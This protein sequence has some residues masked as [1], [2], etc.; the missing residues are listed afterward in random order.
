MQKRSKMRIIISIYRQQHWGSGT[1]G[2]LLQIPSPESMEFSI[3]VFVSC[4]SNAAFFG[5]CHSNPVAVII[6]HKHSD[7]WT[8]S[9]LFAI[10]SK[11]IT[12]S[13]GFRTNFFLEPNNYQTI[14]IVN[15]YFRI[16][17]INKSINLR[18]LYQVKYQK[19]KEK[20]NYKWF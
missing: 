20:L 3:H 13:I 16:D 9:R 1:L 4:K 18:K 15:V 17:K 7:K 14:S 2:Y 8:P 19:I 12:I 11:F 6:M 10:K 5:P